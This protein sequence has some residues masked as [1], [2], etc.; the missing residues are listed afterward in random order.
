MMKIKMSLILPIFLAFYLQCVAGFAIS[1]ESVGNITRQAAA[2]QGTNEIAVFTDIHL[3][4][5]M[6]NDIKSKDENEIRKRLR[7]LGH[8]LIVDTEKYFKLPSFSSYGSL[9]LK[10]VKVD[11]WNPKDSLQNPH[12]KTIHNGPRVPESMLP[13]FKNYTSQ[14]QNNKGDI[15][16]LLTS[17]DNQG[18]CPFNGIANVGTACSA[19]HNFIVAQ[20][21]VREAKQCNAE[22]GLAHEIGHQLG[23]Y[24]DGHVDTENNGKNSNNCE[25]DGSRFI[26]APS[27]A[28]PDQWSRCSRKYIDDFI[29][30]LN[31]NNKNCFKN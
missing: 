4:N 7:H 23:I 3:W 21:S 17:S 29:S 19:G 31:R 24:H 2:N 26:M 13:H 30:E 18:K 27:F 14:L 22:V 11:I 9:N 20:I 10:V 6:K 16:I 15:N 1:P 25:V 8:Q 5:T 28:S 12:I